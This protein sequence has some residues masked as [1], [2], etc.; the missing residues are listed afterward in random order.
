VAA[1]PEPLLLTVSTFNPRVAEETS[2][3]W[4]YPVGSRILFLKLT[5][6]PLSGTTVIE[7]RWGLRSW[8]DGVSLAAFLAAL[9]SIA[10]W[11]LGRFRPAVDPRKV[12][13]A[14]A[15]ARYNPELR[16]W[17]RASRIYTPRHR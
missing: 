4:G 7:L 9:A 3:A 14:L 16:I 11:T 8:G 1:S 15:I 10:A 6:V 12:I 2:R 13:T 17:V 5:V